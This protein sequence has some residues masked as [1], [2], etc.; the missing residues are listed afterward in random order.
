MLV[1]AA[2]SLLGKKSDGETAFKWPRGRGNTQIS[3]ETENERK[4]SRGTETKLSQP[5]V[6]PFSRIISGTGF[7]SRETRCR[8]IKNQPRKRV[9]NMPVSLVCDWFV[10]SLLNHQSPTHWHFCGNKNKRFDLKDLKRSNLEKVLWKPNTDNTA[11]PLIW[12]YPKC[13]QIRG[14]AVKLK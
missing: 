9:T 5:W 12:K 14:L 13:F 8:L 4:E 6:M 11:S 1:I 10:Y 2:G 3:R 7:R